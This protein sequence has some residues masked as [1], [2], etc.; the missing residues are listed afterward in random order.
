MIDPAVLLPSSVGLITRTLGS[1]CKASNGP[2]MAQI[3]RSLVHSLLYPWLDELKPRPIP[4]SRTLQISLFHNSKFC[5]DEHMAI[6]LF[7]SK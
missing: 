1:P 3:F 7:F 5:R 4:W 6:S 2:W